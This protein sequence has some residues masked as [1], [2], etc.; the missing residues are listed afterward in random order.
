MYYRTSTS[1]QIFIFG[2]SNSERTM[3]PNRR[4]NSAVLR[5]TQPGDRLHVDGAVRALAPAVGRR[6]VARVWSLSGRPCADPH[7]VGCNRLA[8][9]A[10]VRTGT[11]GLAARRPPLAG[12]VHPKGMKGSMI[13]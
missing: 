3:Q 5:T 6:V 1:Y 7:W 4:L 13:S 2:T 11:Q 9:R 10:R 12:R 8:R